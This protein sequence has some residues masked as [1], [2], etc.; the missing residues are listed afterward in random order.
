MKKN[1]LRR[2]IIIVIVTI[3]CLYIVLGPR[4]RDAEGKLQLPKASDFTAS[5]I[6]QTLRDNIRLGLDLRGGSQLGMQVQTDVY[7]K[8]LTENTAQAVETGAKAAGY[9]VKEVRPDVSNRNYAITLTTDDTAKLNEMRDELPKKVDL[10]NWTANVS[11]NSITWSL[12]SA[13]QRD[14]SESAADQA[15]RLAGSRL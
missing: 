11:G 6:K 10:Q 7:L 9:N 2:V 13:A 3:A 1:L 15:A 8:R 14:L 5:G 12:T 4:R